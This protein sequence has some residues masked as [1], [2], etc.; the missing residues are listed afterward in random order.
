MPSMFSHPGREYPEATTSSLPCTMYVREN[1]P[2]VWRCTCSHPFYPACF[3]TVGGGIT[4]LPTDT[5]GSCEQVPSLQ[6][7]APN[8]V[9]PMP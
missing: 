6:P 4:R 2:R 7:G 1:L 3:S 9:V 5:P 8:L